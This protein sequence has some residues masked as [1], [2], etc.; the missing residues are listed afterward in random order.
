MFSLAFLTTTSFLLALLATPFVR[1]ICRRASVG[2]DLSD[3]DR[4]L[5]RG[6]V[7]R[8]GGIPILFAYV[9][10]IGLLLTT[11]AVGAQVMWGQ[12]ALVRAI[13]PA[14]IVIFVLGVWDDL[15]GLRA[16]VKFAIQVIAALLVVM[17][18]LRV[19]SVAG[20]VLD[21]DWLSVSITVFWLVLSTN[22]FNLIDG[23]DGLAAGVGLFATLTMLAAGL[24][25]GNFPLALA[26][27]PLAGALLGFL[28]Y[29]FNPASVFLGDSGSYT[30]GFLLGCFGLAWS[31]KAATVIG[32]TAPLLA[33]ALPLVDTALSIVRRF[34]RGQ[35]IFSGDRGHIHHRL[36][37]RGLTVRQAVLVLYAA[38]G[39]CA[40]LSLLGGATQNKF[41][42]VV[43]VLFGV[44]TWAGI[45]SLGYTEF[46]SARHFLF[47]G[48]F[49]RA[50]RADMDLRL[51]RSALETANTW[52]EKWHALVAY[53]RSAG[54]SRVQWQG[55]AKTIDARLISTLNDEWVVEV[56]LGLGGIVRLWQ[57]I[58]HKESQS[59]LGRL[60]AVLRDFLDHAEPTPA[61]SPGKRVRRK[62]IGIQDPEVPLAMLISNTDSSGSLE[63]DRGSALRRSD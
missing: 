16:G 2:L 3:G 25:G 51:L 33:M 29:N 1:N 18:G 48:G 55:G 26:T 34:L 49:Q 21:N 62:A 12:M 27:A 8:V 44:A 28:R 52:E 6:A 17:G 42:G 38:S 47:G 14:V 60:V 58:A 40:G 5:H 45:Q 11:H 54:F 56:P 59:A 4:K 22:A 63:G 32:M 31:Q 43:L 39:L 15:R 36:L 53:S 57:E 24:I 35:P 10:S 61:Q 13:A 19:V 7:P 23:L 9:C 46:Q 41:S 50:L 30:T 20:F 37:Q